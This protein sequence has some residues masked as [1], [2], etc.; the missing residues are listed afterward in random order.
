MVGVQ[1]SLRCRDRGTRLC[2]TKRA[3]P[4]RCDR[5]EGLR[6]RTLTAHA[7]SAP[8][9]CR[10]FRS[11]PP[12]PNALST[13]PCNGQCLPPRWQRPATFATGRFRRGGPI[14][15]NCAK[16]LSS[17]RRRGRIM[18]P[19]I[20]APRTRLARAIAVTA[21]QARS[22]G[23]VERLT[24]PGGFSAPTRAPGSER[25][26]PRI[27]SGIGNDTDS[28]GPAAHRDVGGAVTD[29]R[30]K[31]ASTGCAACVLRGVGPAGAGMRRASCAET[32]A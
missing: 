19:E 4:A 20:A 8:S 22:R 25:M 23:R 10:K 5:R 29:G 7:G 2:K 12:S 28:G 27:Q 11:A 18:R 30:L 17:S 9:K 13:G 31:L 6:E 3:G 15:H 14:P 1:R 32:L 16:T 21:A 26:L 24:H